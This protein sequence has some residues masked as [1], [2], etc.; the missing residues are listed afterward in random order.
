MGS[1][2]RRSTR[3][4]STVLELENSTVDT[5]ASPG[6]CFWRSIMPLKPPMVSASSPAMEPLLSSMNTI[7][8][9]S[10]FIAI[11][12]CL[13][14]ALSYSKNRGKRS[15]AV[16]HYAMEPEPSRGISNWNSTS[17]IRN[18]S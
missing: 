7:S 3:S 5:Y 1:I 16:R 4:W 17:L 2:F 11:P 13:L 12:S 14:M 8:V 18:M 10:F 6:C 9:R 15:P